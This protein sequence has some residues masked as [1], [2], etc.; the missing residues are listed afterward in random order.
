MA[1]KTIQANMWPNLAAA[2]GCEKAAISRE[3]G[4]SLMTLAQVAVAQRRVRG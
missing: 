1:I 2:Q 3:I 4:A